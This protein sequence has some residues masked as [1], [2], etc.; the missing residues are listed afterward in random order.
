MVLT[1]FYMKVFFFVQI[2]RKHYREKLEKDF[3]SGFI[4]STFPSREM[5]KI[6]LQKS[7]YHLFFSSWFLSLVENTSHVTNRSEHGLVWLWDWDL[8]LGWDWKWKAKSVQ[9]FSANYHSGISY[10]DFWARSIY[11]VVWLYHYIDKSISHAFF[12]SLL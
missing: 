4:P 11:I 9:F 10:F 1:L 7:S 5:K 8:D 12:L 3:S 6:Q 2:G